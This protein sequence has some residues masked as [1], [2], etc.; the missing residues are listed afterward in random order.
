MKL[1]TKYLRYLTPEDWRVLEAIDVGSRN[2]EIVPTPL[3]EKFA[4]LRSG[5]GETNR[6]ISDLAKISL[7]SKV[8]NAK[9]DGYRL[10][11][12]GLDYLALHSM[13]K[14]HTFKELITTIGVGKE[15]DIYSAL[16]PNDEPRVLKIHRLGRVSFRSVKNKRDYLRNKHA[17]SWM[18]L[19]KLSAEREWSFMTALH[20]NGFSV[21]IPYDYTSHC[22]LMEKVDGFT[23]KVLREYRYYKRLYNQLMQFIVRLAQY[24]MIHGDFNEYNI[25]I[26]NDGTWDPKKGCGFVVID[27]PQ[28]VSIEHPDASFYFQRDVECIRR[29]FKRRFKYVPKEKDGKRGDNDGWGDNFKHAYPV[30]ERDVQRKSDLDLQVKASGY[31]S[32]LNAKDRD[33]S[34]AIASMSKDHVESESEDEDEDDNEDDSENVDDEQEVEAQDNNKDDSNDESSENEKII[35]ALSSGQKLKKDALGNYI[36]DN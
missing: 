27:F 1:E 15:S 16:G 7:I 33:L 22:V 23:M 31:R 17:Q 30:F 19:S 29:F 12:N 24:G 10:T 11:Y 36:L 13:I 20:E 32:K 25:M 18:Y 9:Y 6:C 26:K 2:H 35:E 34:G 28:C 14:N 4:N 5:K 21:P 3:I 8:R